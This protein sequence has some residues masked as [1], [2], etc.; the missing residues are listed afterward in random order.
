MD[1]AFAMFMENYEYNDSFL[2]FLKEHFCYED[3]FEKTYADKSTQ[4]E[5]QFFWSYFS[6]SLSS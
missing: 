4:T 6:W 3:V 5:K 1:Y 2:D